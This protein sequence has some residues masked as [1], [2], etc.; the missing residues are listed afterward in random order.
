MKALTGWRG[1]VLSFSKD[2][3]NKVE[4]DYDKWAKKQYMY[5]NSY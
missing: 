5:R 3:Q 1:D 2:I 4:E